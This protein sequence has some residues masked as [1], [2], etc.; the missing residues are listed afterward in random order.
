M[1]ISANPNRYHDQHWSRLSQTRELTL[2][3]PALSSFNSSTG[4]TLLSDLG[5]R[6]GLIARG[7]VMGDS[8]PELSLLSSIDDSEGICTIKRAGEAMGLLSI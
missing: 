5:G 8:S 6:K 7:G 4:D 2:L 1:V 3:S